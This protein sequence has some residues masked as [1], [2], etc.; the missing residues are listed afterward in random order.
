MKTIHES[1]EPYSCLSAAF[2]SLQID[3]ITAKKNK[4]ISAAQ[5][6]TP[7]QNFR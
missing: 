5:M 6:T 3:V 7:M 1:L 2:A 4:T